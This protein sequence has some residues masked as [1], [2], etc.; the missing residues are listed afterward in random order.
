MTTLSRQMGWPFRFREC[1]RTLCNGGLQYKILFSSSVE[2]D[3]VGKSKFYSYFI[4]TERLV[5]WLLL[6]FAIHM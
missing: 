5:V 1:Y 3:D 6:L 4:Q 2:K